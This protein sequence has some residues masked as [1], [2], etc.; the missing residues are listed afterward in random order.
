MRVGR[1]E[2][3]KKGVKGDENTLLCMVIYGM[4]LS[5]SA[6]VSCSLVAVGPLS[7]VVDT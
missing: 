2:R 6:A 5:F 1:G 4:T 7:L 3:G